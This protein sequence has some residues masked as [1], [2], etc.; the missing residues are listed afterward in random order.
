M[1]GF[2][3]IF[4]FMFTEN[5]SNWI[6]NTQ[7]IL[8]FFF[9]FK[10]TGYFICLAHW[11][12]KHTFAL[13]LKFSQSISVD[14]LII[15]IFLH[16]ADT[17]IWVIRRDQ[18]SSRLRT[19]YVIRIATRAVVCAEMNIEQSPLCASK[20]QTNASYTESWF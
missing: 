8:S 2:L 4:D 13:V 17:I 6:W 15:H 19:K 20:K 9:V 12:I 14:S 10:T 1:V 16:I 11:R 5:A 7:I 3:Y 18:S